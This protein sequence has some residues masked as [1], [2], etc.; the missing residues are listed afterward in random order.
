MPFKIVRNDIT[1]MNVDAIVNTANSLPGYGAGTD[2]AVYEAAGAE[3]LCAARAAIGEI[4]CGASA[5]TEGF[6]LPARY[7]IHTVGCPWNGGSHGEETVIR[8]CYQSAFAEAASLKVE[9]LAVPLLASGSFGCPKSVAMDI[10]LSE[11]KSFLYDHDMEIFL[12]VF[13]DESYTISSDRFGDIDAYISRNYV[14]ET[15]SEEYS[16]GFFTYAGDYEEPVAG[17]AA[18]RKPGRKEGKHFLSRQDFMFGLSAAKQSESVPS[19]SLAEMDVDGAARPPKTLDDVVKNLDKTFMELVF[20]YADEK[21]MT[22]VELQKKA[23]INRKAF[24]KL[25]CGTTKNPSKATALCFAIALELSL[26]ETRDLLSRA[27]LALSPCSKQDV[28]VQYFIEKGAYDIFEIN[29]AL[30]AHGVE[31]IGDVEA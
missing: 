27:G 21:G 10:A 30:F 31:L 29:N 28:I 26:D 9:T 15:L 6:A 1:K 17:D 18:P 16:Q 8:S 5:V 22:D 14:E 24:S 19:F 11:I 23:N 20:T 3:A 25:R 13:D 2:K 7:I 4:A 12:V